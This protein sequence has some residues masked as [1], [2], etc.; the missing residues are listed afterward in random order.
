MIP[1]LRGARWNPP[2]VA[3]LYGSFELDTAIAEGDHL[4]AVQGLPLK[5]SRTVYT[6]GLELHNV[7]EL[8]NEDVLEKLGLPPL[9]READDPTPCQVVGGAAEWLGHDGIIVPSV[10]HSGQNF[11]IYTAKMR[12]TARLE[13]VSQQAL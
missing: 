12:P 1:N 6:I 4:I 8:T 2:D 11:V 9:V 3:A 5:T 10:R 7:L 13:V